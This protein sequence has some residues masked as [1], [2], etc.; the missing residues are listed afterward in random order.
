[1]EVG[2][3][4]TITSL[5]NI[6][7]FAIGAFSSTP[8]IQLFCISNATAMFFD[9]L[10]TCTAYLAIVAIGAKYEMKFIK[11]QEVRQI[12]VCNHEEKGKTITIFR[13]NFESKVS[14]LHLQ[15]TYLVL[16]N[17]KK[18][19]A[20]CFELYAEIGSLPCISISAPFALLL[21]IRQ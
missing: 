1:M 8:D 17:K 10:Y 13:P 3:S 19:M 14:T 15:A 7:A 9:L 5:T 6:I 20:R 18:I 2:P 11:K 12:D 4:I 21:A 16:V